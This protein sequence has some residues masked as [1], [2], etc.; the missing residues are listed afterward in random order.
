MSLQSFLQFLLLLLYISSINGFSVNPSAKESSS[1]IHFKMIHRHAPELLG[2][3]KLT[4]YDR[5]Q[6][7]L[8]ADKL[9]MNILSHKRKLRATS[10]RRELQGDGT[11]FSFPLLSGEST[12]TAS[13]YV[14]FRVGT[15]AQ[16]FLLLVDTG[17]DLTWMNC[18]FR[19]NEN[20]IGSHCS[21]PKDHNLTKRAFYPE[22]SQTFR[23]VPCNSTL[24][25]Q[26]FL[27]LNSNPEMCPTPN[28]PCSYD[29]PYA[30][31]EVAQGVYAYESV[32]VK[33][34]NGVEKQIPD[35]LIGCTREWN[36]S[37][38]MGKADGIFGLGFNSHG[39]V[40]NIYKNFQGKFSYCLMDQYNTKNLS[41]YL[42]FGNR[43]PQEM[44][45]NMQYAVLGTIGDHFGVTVE[46]IY[47]DGVK[48]NISDEV[49][50]IEKG[51]GMM[52]DSGFS[53]TAW[54]PVAYDPIIAALENPL[55][56]KFTSVKFE[57]F[58]SCFKVPQNNNNATMYESLVP[59]F[60]IQFLSGVRLKPAVRTYFID[61]DDTGVK[62]FGFN[63]APEG[64][65]SGSSISILG[66]IMQQNHMWE[67]DIL[68]DRLGFA[69]SSCSLL[70]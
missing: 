47:V 61:V 5:I 30:S 28:S 32:T 66:N 43:N 16:E 19:C 12:G 25:Q 57:G 67:F 46:G 60:E 40:S 69:P 70:A 26:G 35:M 48:L 64:D 33:L 56:G 4:H 9:R 62:C 45:P 38:G 21:N 6:E 41:N 50:N 44:P 53:L 24:C 3:K 31:T 2:E 39:F 13:Y 54:V 37:Y 65:A 7:L 55:K 22:N 14:P 36:D 68:G 52:V 10:S 49:W 1:V 29:Y 42:T 8:H 17:S 27:N 51:G 15:P 11:S 20:N 59:K 18:R 23:T 63:R 34:N 58:D